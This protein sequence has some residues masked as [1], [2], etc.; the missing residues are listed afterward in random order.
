MDFNGQMFIMNVVVADME[1]T[2]VIVGL[3]FLEYHQSVIDTKQHMLDLK[4]LV[5]PI[6]LHK[7][8]KMVPLTEIISVTLENDLYIP[9]SSQLEVVVKLTGD[10]NYIIRRSEC[11][12]QT[13]CVS[14][15]RSCVT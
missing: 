12:T 2:E 1:K 10:S 4:G 14:C 15:H 11:F 8:V 7:Q 9:G 6:P 5:C 13:L 3:N